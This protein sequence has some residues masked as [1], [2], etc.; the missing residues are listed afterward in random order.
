MFALTVIRS[1]PLRR[2]LRYA[3]Y[4]RALVPPSV[5]EPL[6]DLMRTVIKDD[7]M[8]GLLDQGRAEGRV[9][10]LLLLL[11]KRFRVPVGVRDGIKACTDATQIDTWFDRAITA[12]SL[13]EVFAE[14]PG[15]QPM[16]RRPPSTDGA[17]GA[18]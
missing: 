17:P 6:E 7:F 3:R 11:G 2:R 13:E 5:R 15:W 18:C 1:A 16:L 10:M 4:I 9:E 8:D 14:L 12:T